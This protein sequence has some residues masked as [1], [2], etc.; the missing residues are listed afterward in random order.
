[1]KYEGENKKGVRLGQDSKG[2]KLNR[3]QKKIKRK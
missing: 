3:K 2:K 1:M